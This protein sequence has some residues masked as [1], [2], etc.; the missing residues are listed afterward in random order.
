[1]KKNILSIILIFTFMLS[2]FSCTNEVTVSSITVD[3][4]SLPES[5]LVENVENEILN[6]KLNVINSDDTTTVV[7]LTKDMISDTDYNKLLTVGTHEI[8]VKYEGVETKI[9]IVVKEDISKYFTVKVVY[10]SKEP[11]TSGVTVQWCTG[12]I[13]E[14]PV[15]V[16]SEGIAVLDVEEGDYYIHIDNI[17]TGYTYDPNAYT[18]NTQNKHIEIEL[19]ELSTY[20]SGDGTA[21]NP[22][23]VSNSAYTATFDAKGFA[24]CQYFSFTATE[25]RTYSI[26]SM[27]MSALAM[28]LVDPYFAFLGTENNIDNRDVSANKESKVDINFTHTFEAEANTTY[29]FI[30][31]VSEANSYP[32]PFDFVIR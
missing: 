17:P 7:T 16:N 18:S 20:A 12:N 28:N 10:P 1:M 8:T 14:L 11:V 6:I 21:E 23:V 29:Y 27:S 26:S 22:Y 25:T 32:A 5:I 3:E 9:T 30:M 31:F 13:C 4:S 15:A 2:L 19:I 24:N